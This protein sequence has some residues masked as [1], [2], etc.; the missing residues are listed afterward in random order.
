MCYDCVANCVNKDIYNIA[1]TQGAKS[2]FFEK[3]RC[4]KFQQMEIL[5]K[6]KS[7]KVHS[8]FGRSGPRIEPSVSHYR[9]E[10]PAGTTGIS[11]SAVPNAGACNY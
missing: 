7:R 2:N 9:D 5:V 4:I 8:P 3:N 1:K 6:A 11:Y 10:Q